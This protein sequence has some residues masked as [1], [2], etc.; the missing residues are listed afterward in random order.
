MK[1]FRGKVVVITG[2]G[3]GMGRAYAQAFARL[4]AH[5]ALNDYD[6]SALSETRQGIEAIK[7]RGKVF[8]MAFDVSDRD[9]MVAFADQVASRLGK[10]H[11]IIN[12]A[13]V[14]GAGKPVWAI[15]EAEYQR[16]FGINFF[17]V[18][19]G[20]QVFLP[21]LLANGEGAVVNVSS[22]FG[23][24]GPPNS[25]DYS[26]TKF[27]V[28]GF[29]ESLM[30]ELMD[31]PI[32]V[33]LVHPG[34]IATNIAKASHT[35]SFSRHYLKTSP[36]DIVAH[37]IK[38]IQRGRQRIVFGNG[39]LKTWLGSKVLPLPLLNRVVWKD[40]GHTLDRSDYP[41]GSD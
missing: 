16:I 12:N 38:S 15:K 18:L 25:S 29:T 5:V 6:A 26:A 11:V 13:G 14:E 33:H 41:P 31:T 23:L 20:T 40:M 4:G 10:A 19:N 36:D 35:Q 1:K 34:G 39:A 32:S 7:G 27:A 9:A 3:S 17:G 21:H 22:I 8:E 28:R 37:V 24:I 2:A 30:A